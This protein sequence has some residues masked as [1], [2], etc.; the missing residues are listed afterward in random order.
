[1]S[2]LMAESLSQISTAK[3][4][5]WLWEPYLARGKLAVLDGDPGIGKSLVTI[6]LA[7]RLSRGD[8]VPGGAPG[9]GPGVT[10]LLSGEDNGE[11]VRARATAAGADL[12]AIAFVSPTGPEP[13]TLPERLSDLEALV[14][15]RVADLVVIDPFLAFLRPGLAVNVDP[16]VRHVLTPLAALAERCDCAVLLVRHLRKAAAARAVYRGLGSVGIVAAARTGLLA[17]RHPTDPTAAVIAVTK[18]NVTAVPPALTYRLRSDAAGRP[19]VEWSA[20]VNVPAD[21]LGQVAAPVP[22]LRPR[23]RAVVW[24]HDELANGPRRASDVRAAAARACIPNRTLERAKGE[25][26]VKSHAAY[27]GD[28]REWWWYDP[29]AP[30]P[31]NAPFRKPNPMELQPLE[32][33][34]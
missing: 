16:C 7:A 13:F 26:R 30:W 25:L 28:V 21:D 10:L 3:P 14:C 17:A 15:D 31:A 22:E 9:N 11:T 1:M 18:S 29:A 4:L 33:L 5:R 6:D 19:V 32:D 23:D 20:P 8:A 34:W 2:T 24:L 27:H 12:G